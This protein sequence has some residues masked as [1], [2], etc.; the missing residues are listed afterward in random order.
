MESI[1]EIGTRIDGVVRAVAM[2][3]I[4]AST[5]ATAL[6]LTG[7]TSRVRIAEFLGVHRNS[8]RLGDEFAAFRLAE[9]AIQ[10]R[11][12]TSRRRRSGT[13]FIDDGE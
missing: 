2:P 7:I 1:R 10:S 12:A 5:M 11:Q 8:L 6:L 9:G 3:H 4:P 13:D